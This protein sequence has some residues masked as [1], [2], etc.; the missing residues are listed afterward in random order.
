[1]TKRPTRRGLGEADVSAREG[2]LAAQPEADSL[3]ADQHLST[4]AIAA[5]VDG[6]LS[7]AAHERATRHLAGCTL[8][9]AEVAT[10]RQARAAM[11]DATPRVPASLLNALHAIPHSVEWPSPGLVVAED[12]TLIDASA[13]SQQQPVVGQTLR[14]TQ[15]IASPSRRR[16]R[17]RWKRLLDASAD[18][19]SMGQTRRAR[20][21][22]PLLQAVGRVGALTEARERAGGPMALTIGTNVAMRQRG[23]PVR[24]GAAVPDG[25]QMNQSSRIAD[26]STRDE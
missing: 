7:L 16:R 12:G 21:K 2:D 22:S 17:P 25:F 15:Q 19:L 13:Q 26:R 10:Q 11:R 24:E 1:M 6:E 3:G 18:A 9:T 5:Y 14:T 23:K 20:F 8:C 4:E